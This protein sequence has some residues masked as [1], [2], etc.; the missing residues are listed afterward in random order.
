MGYWK[1]EVVLATLIYYP[2]TTLQ[3][4]GN[5][6]KVKTLK[7][8]NDCVL[9]STLLH[10]YNLSSVDFKKN[11]DVSEGGSAPFFK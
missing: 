10:I 6:M 1:E 11:N 4:L 9:H 8:S 7:G 2:K 3:R 5:N